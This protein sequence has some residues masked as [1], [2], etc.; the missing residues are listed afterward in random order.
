[1]QISEI[2]FLADW[3]AI[4]LRWLCLIGLSI[5][6]ALAD[7]MTL[8]IG[9]VLLMLILWNCYLSILAISNRRMISHRY[10]NVIVDGISMIAL[11]VLSKGVAGPI[12]WVGLFPLFSTAIYFGL[13]WSLA[14]GLVIS[15][16]EAGIVFLY[17]TFSAGPKPLLVL[18][19]FNLLVGFILGVISEQLVEHLRGRYFLLLRQRQEAEQRAK[20]QEKD[21]LQAFYELTAT[22]ISTLNYQTV[23]DTALDLGAKAMDDEPESADQ[24]VSAVLLFDEDHLRVGSSRR[25]GPNDQRITLP[26]REGLVAQAL[27]SPGPV[28]AADPGSDLELGRFTSLRNCHSVVCLALRSRLNV[29]GVL[30]F[31]HPAANHFTMERCEVLEVMNRQAVVAI[32][33]ALLYRDLEREKE[34]IIET[35]EEARKKLARDLHDGPTQSVAALAM[36]INFTRRLLE[37]DPKTAEE[38]LEKI[39]D[40]AR[41]ATKEIRHMLFTLRPLVLES[42]GLVPAMQAMAETMKETYG[43]EVSIEVDPAVVSQLELGKQTVV[44][45]LAEEAVNNARKHAQ[46]PH[47]WVRLKMLKKEKDIALLEVQDDGV[48]FDVE[49]INSSYERRGS[50]GMVNLRERTDLLNGLLHLQSTKGQGARVHVYFPLTEEAADLLHRGV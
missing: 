15:L 30:L 10:I 29:Y 6:L 41:R 13:L 45:Y 32:Q 7:A 21:R 25:M 31:A 42:Q 48:G 39:E 46:A 34:R 44:F 38:E 18:I 14:T 24:M 22:L 20:K 43:Q 12:L 47:I 3:F 28:I 19:I 40:L 5:G 8:A 23:L 9:I 33:N 11:F 49:D 17:G 26:G 27:K 50:L 1:M 2:P 37:K 4:L 16:I 36:R 35:Q